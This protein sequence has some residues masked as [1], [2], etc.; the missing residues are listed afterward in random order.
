MVVLVVAALAIGARVRAL[1]IITVG[2]VLAALS[3]LLLGPNPKGPDGLIP[4]LRHHY[5][6]AQR[7]GLFDGTYATPAEVAPFF[8]E[9]LELHHGQFSYWAFSD[10]VS[11]SE[12]AYPL[13][14]HFRID[15][16]RVVLEV[17]ILIRLVG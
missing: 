1:A 5:R 10:V 17:P 8:G 4:I 9:V 12:P 11:R 2:G 15:G 14:G 7:P 6:E 3:V 16:D 13:R